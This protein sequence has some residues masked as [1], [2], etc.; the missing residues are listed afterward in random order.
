MGAYDEMTVDLTEKRIYFNY[1]DDNDSISQKK[2]EKVAV[3]SS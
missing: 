1:V 3:I 2:Y